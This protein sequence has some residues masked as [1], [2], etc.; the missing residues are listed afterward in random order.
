MLGTVENVNKSLA[1][2]EQYV[3][4]FV[5]PSYSDTYIDLDLKHYFRGKLV[6]SSH[7]DVDFIQRHYNFSE[8]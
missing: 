6:S 2:V 3:L 7:E 5:I 1:A 8:F 4:E